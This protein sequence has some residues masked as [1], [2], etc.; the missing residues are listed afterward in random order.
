M[1]CSVNHE[2]NAK[3]SLVSGARLV[4]CSLRAYRYF[5]ADTA[6]HAISY[7]GVSFVFK[8]LASVSPNAIE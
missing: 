7:I 2:R 1:P 5:V 6:D 3:K 8:K 4:F